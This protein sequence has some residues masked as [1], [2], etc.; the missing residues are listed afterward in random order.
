MDSLSTLAVV[1]ITL[2]VWGGAFCTI[3]ALCIYAGRDAEKKSNMQLCL[4][5]HEAGLLLL[6]DA[7]AI[8]FRGYPG[9]IGA[10]IVRVS[11]YFVFAILYLL[12]F[13]FYKYIVAV[14][15]EN[16]GETP[17]WSK[18]AVNVLVLFGEVS[19]IASQFLG[20]YYYFDED[21]IYH[22]G[23]IFEV[24]QGL[25]ILL[26]LICGIVASLN[27]KKMTVLEYIGCM[28][29]LLLPVGA[30]IVQI[31]VYGI[32]LLNMAIT[33][34]VLFMFATY[35][36]ERGTKLEVQ[37]KKLIQQERKNTEW[38]LALSQ[39]QMKPHFVYNCLNSIQ[40]LCK[41][42]PE[43]ASE[44][45]IRFSKFLRATMDSSKM[46]K[47]V[48]VEEELELLNNYLYL[49]H[50]RFG[51]KLKV[52]KDIATTSFSIPPLTIQPMVE[53]AIKHGICQRIEGGTVEIRTYEE[54]DEYIVEVED[55]G[56]GFDKEQVGQDGQLHVGLTN[57]KGRL[58]L[59]CKG[60]LEVDSTIGDGTKI[61]IHIP[62]DKAV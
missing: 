39:S 35:E 54:S 28:S 61:R 52:K 44:A 10:I 27:Y 47:C 25:G 36:V 14:V 45:T 51:K 30:M 37:A 24:T 17:K 43:L 32:S 38:Q 1:Q 62:K 26:M 34:S 12:G 18:Y 50:L 2:Q 49:E 4:M 29:Y 33:L 42:D 9:T 7:A 31:N 53:N 15:S 22:R 21:N 19:L 13:N 48:P 3:A 58:E 11:N 20:F 5:L 59:M 23:E 46:M 57:V 40:Y 8:G 60:K 6:A 16:D 56:V 55:D 41:K